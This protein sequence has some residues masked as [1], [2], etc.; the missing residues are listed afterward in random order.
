M[1]RYGLN[2]T[3]ID[4]TQHNLFTSATLVYADANEHALG[5]VKEMEY[6][7]DL[8]AEIKLTYAGN[9]ADKNLTFGIATSN[10]ELT[11]ANSISQLA[12]NYWSTVVIDL[13]TSGGTSTDYYKINI[14]ASEIN[15]KYLYS[16]YQYEGEPTNDPTVEVKLNYI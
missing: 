13:D 6:Y 5:D 4:G 11:G 14:P 1:D 2:A 9:P 7:K 10:Y 12:L 3:T 8:V 16:K 15:G